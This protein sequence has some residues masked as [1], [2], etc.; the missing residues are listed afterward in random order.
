MFFTDR[1]GAFVHERNFY[2]SA[3]IAAAQKPGHSRR[4]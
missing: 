1:E 3:K 2:K 4:Q